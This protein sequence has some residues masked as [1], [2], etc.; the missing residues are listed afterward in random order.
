M[1][2]ELINPETRLCA[3]DSTVLISSKYDS[4]AKSCKYTSLCYFN[5]YKLHCIATKY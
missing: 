5:G 4:K 1:F 2:I 3:I